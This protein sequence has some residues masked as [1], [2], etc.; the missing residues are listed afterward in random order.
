MPKDTPRGRRLHR[1][2]PDDKAQGGASVRTLR[3]ELGTEQR[4]VQRVAAQLG[5]GTESVRFWMRQADSRCG[6]GAGSE[7]GGGGP[8]QGVGADID[9]SL[10]IEVTD[11][12]KIFAAAMRRVLINRTCAT[13]PGFAQNLDTRRVG[14]QIS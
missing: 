6:P 5:Y 11:D 10:F 2:T 4:T 13:A 1:N 14:R 8:N 7:H 9:R 12:P 3:A